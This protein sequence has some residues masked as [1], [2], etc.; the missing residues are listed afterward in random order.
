MSQHYYAGCL[1]RERTIARRCRRNNG[2]KERGA[3]SSL[4]SLS[5]SLLASYQEDGDEEGIEKERERNG[6]IP[7]TVSEA[8]QPARQPPPLAEGDR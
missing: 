3:C 7:P 2:A 6:L 1:R 4:L 5:L 8:G